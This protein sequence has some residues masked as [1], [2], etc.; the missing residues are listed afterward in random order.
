M[1]A[2]TQSNPITRPG[3]EMLPSG[4]E[5]GLDPRDLTTNALVA[6]GHEPMSPLKALRLRCLDCCVGSA[7]EVRMCVSVKCPAWPFRMGMNPWRAPASEAQKE[8][9][10]A[11]I[12][13]LH[14]IDATPADAPSG[15]GE[16]ERNGGAGT[17]LPGCASPGGSAIVSGRAA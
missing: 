15:R 6:L 5:R 12:A 2:G 14:K 7:N 13:R 1:N 10:R 4:D 3:V 11:N 9:S 17:S 8:A 16:F